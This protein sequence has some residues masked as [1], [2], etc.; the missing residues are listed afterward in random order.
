MEKIKLFLIS[1]RGKNILIVLIVILVGLSSFELGR[2]SKGTNSSSGIKILSTQGGE[3]LPQ[4]ANT[5]SVLDTAQTKNN[6]SSATST[7]SGK[8]F[9]ASNRGTKYYSVGCSGG[10]TIK[11]ENRVY[12]K[13]KED[14]ERA[15]YVLSTSCK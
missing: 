1:E 5:I 15:G 12:F 13:T 2:L 3:Y 7:S 8:N 4:E 10:K 11:P 6:I 9:F 14:A